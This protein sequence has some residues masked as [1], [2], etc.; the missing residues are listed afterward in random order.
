MDFCVCLTALALPSPCI[1][2]LEW[3]QGSSSAPVHAFK[4]WQLTC[5]EILLQLMNWLIPLKRF[6][7]CFSFQINRAMHQL[8]QWLQMKSV[9]VASHTEAGC[10]KTPWVLEMSAAVAF[11]GSPCIDCRHAAFFFFFFVPV[12][13]QERCCILH[14]PKQSSCE[15]DGDQSWQVKYEPVDLNSSNMKGTHTCVHLRLKCVCIGH[16]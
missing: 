3:Q 13:I 2:S 4:G 5:H 9:F 10:C 8:W 12:K 14:R 16:A 11:Y 1:G 7:A 6:M 15:G